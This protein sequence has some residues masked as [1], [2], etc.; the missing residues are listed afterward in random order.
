MGGEND[1]CS[2]SGV[3]FFPGGSSWSDCTEV[4]SGTETLKRVCRVLQPNPDEACFECNVIEHQSS[5]EQ[6]WSK[7]PGSNSF[8]ELQ[9]LE[10]NLRF[11]V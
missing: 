4:L 3:D 5:S 2:A 8:A 6:G 11:W 10:I 9:L 7:E 1:L